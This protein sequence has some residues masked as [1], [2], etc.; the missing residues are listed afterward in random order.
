MQETLENSRR[1]C[2]FAGN[3]GETDYPR[4]GLNYPQKLREKGESA[5]GAAQKAAHFPADRQAGDA[6]LQAIIEAWPKLPEAI[7]AGILAMI[8]AAGGQQG[9]SGAST[10]STSTKPHNPQRKTGV[11]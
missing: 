1:E 8:R 9:V 3:S 6:D 4:Q 7:R 10:L 5:T 2:V 11:R